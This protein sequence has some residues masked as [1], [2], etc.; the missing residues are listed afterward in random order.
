ME[1]IKE[2]ITIEIIKEEK[3]KENMPWSEKY[4]GKKF[5][6][7]KGQ[8]F[9]IDKLRMFIRS[10]PKKKGVVLH[11][12][13]GTGKTSLAY[14]LAAE[15]QAEIIEMNA[16]DLRN[17]E[18]VGK[19]IKPASQQQ[20]LFK[21]NK[22]ILVDE[23]D[24]IS[25]RAD[26]GGLSEL[27]TI[28][29]KSQFP[30]VITAND[31]WDK[32]FNLLRQNSDLVQLKEVEYRSLV[33]ILKKICE[34][35][36]IQINNDI[37]VSIAIKARGDVRAAINDLQN[38]SLLPESNLVKEIGERNKEISIFNALQHIFKNSKIDFK[39]LDIYDEVDMN[40]DEIFLWVDEN[41]PLEYKGEELWKAYDALSRADVF[42][43]R[44]HRQQHWRFLVY[45]H[46]FLGAGIAAAK[47]YNRSG[48]TSYKKPTRILKIWLKNQRDAKK[49]T[50]CHK[51]ARACHISIKKAKR[52]FLLIRQILKN[53]KVRDSLKLSEEE[54]EYLEKPI[55]V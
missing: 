39:M 32:K 11:G 36:K 37:L 25:A 41:I 42:K 12:P 51:Y 31:I 1:E 40:I 55:G 26:F 17:K 46:F 4:R 5:E 21:K 15:M 53:Q 20:S 24:G 45:E 54:N 49:E 50:I 22:I 18:Q 2:N 19:I 29:D 6:D 9:A 43:G 34:K 7:L 27:L 44:I 16:S 8:D 48:F 10:F 35:E 33:E 3:K 38:L 14:A 47:K 23:V 30:V 28:L 52:E 13:A